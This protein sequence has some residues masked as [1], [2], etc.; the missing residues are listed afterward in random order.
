MKEISFPLRPSIFPQIYAFSDSHEQ[1]RGLLKVGFTEREDVSQRMKEIYPLKT[2]GRNTWDLELVE[3]AVRS[4][5]SV[6]IDKEVHRILRRLGISNPSGE[7]FECDV[8]TVRMAILEARTGIRA[9]KGRTKD[10]G[11]RP[12]QELAV[13]V[14]KSYF[15]R[16]LKSESKKPPH[17]LWNAKMRF[18]KT[19]AT[20]HLAKAM[21]W[22]RVLV[23]TFMPVVQDAWEDDLNTHVDFADWRFFSAKDSLITMDEKVP[24]V[25]FGSFQDL[26]G[27]NRKTGGI[28]T[29]NQWIHKVDWDLVVLDEYHFGAWREKP[30]SL[31]RTEDE[32][33]EVQMLDSA[34]RDFSEEGLPIQTRAFLYLSGTPFR[35]LSTGEFIE[36]Q[37]FNWTYAD[38][39]R[40]KRNWKTD[41][42]PYQELPEML[43]MTYKIPDSISR[44]AKLGEF[45]EFDLDTFFSAEGAGESAS[46]K[47]KDEVQ[48]WLDLIRGT[49]EEDTVPNLKLGKNKPPFPFSNSRLLAILTHTVWRL[50]GVASCFAMRNLLL[51]R[52]NVYFHDFKIIVA[53]GNEAGIGLAALDKWKEQMQDPLKT[54]SITLTCRKLL[55]GVTVPPW[56][57]IFML[58]NLSTPESYFQSMFRVQSPWVIDLVDDQG[59]PSRRIMK[60]Q[61][62]VFDF[63]PERALRLVADYG[64]R[65]SLEDTNP[66]QKIE[67][68][69]QFLPILAYSGGS[70]KQIDATGVLEM[71]LTGTTATLL[72]NKLNN[73]LLVNVDNSTLSKLLSNQKAIEAIMNI[74][75]FRN[76]KQ[77]IEIIINKSDFVKKVQKQVNTGDIGEKKKREL[78]EA[79]KE[80]RR[81]RE[82]IQEKLLKFASRLT[83]FLYLTDF[84]ES[85]LK[86]VIT[87]LEP[88]LFTRVTGLSIKEFQLLL[89]IGLFNDRL[90][91]DVILA[92]RLYEDASLR[93]LGIQ[94]HEDLRF[95][96]FDTVIS[97]EDARILGIDAFVSR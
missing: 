82:E 30:R 67:E 96:L 29:K 75:G 64:C 26:L 4:D 66:I 72:A 85:C 73:A 63:A 86:D 65:L 27:R 22:K 36:E 89:S 16:A 44:V 68:F 69:L 95:G 58:C 32:E 42:N 40:E 43:M 57:G 71:A 70:L 24:M 34:L 1:Y 83:L 14:T 48:K 87:L 38:E 31:L 46:F 51:E 12:E 5:G 23:I 11:M 74:V 20:Y 50:P 97:G 25:Y 56:T 61:C 90:M 91:N 84:R 62:Y 59:N 80:Y 3:S 45:N 88:N 18:G 79:E 92:F 39:Q 2:P 53:A 15:E 54:R 28:K 41:D 94:K 81:R 60:E 37:I 55:T 7:W 76:I 6:F 77:D 49:W 8:D 13:E 9:E 19:F 52:Q 33:L 10:F 47:H 93:Y 17:F 21:K 78:T 35:A